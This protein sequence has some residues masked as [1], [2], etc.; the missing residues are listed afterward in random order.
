MQ[1]F[2]LSWYEFTSLIH[3]ISST[4]LVEEM[5]NMHLLKK[6]GTPNDFVP[7]TLIEGHSK[8]KMNI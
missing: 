1:L 8:E 6:Q 7:L 2:T 4:I 5:A 3:S